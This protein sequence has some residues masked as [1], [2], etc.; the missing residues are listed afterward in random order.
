VVT[1]DGRVSIVDPVGEF[2]SEEVVGEGCD[3]AVD[4]PAGPETQPVSPVIVSTP[5]AA[6]RSDRRSIRDGFE[7][8]DK[9]FLVIE[10][11]MRP[12]LFCLHYDDLDDLFSR[13]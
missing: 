10:M 6:W 1:G 7:V 13:D 2:C 4:L 11:K 3:P 12:F 9:C 5:V 8:F